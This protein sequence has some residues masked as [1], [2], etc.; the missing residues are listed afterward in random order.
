MN[1]VPLMNKDSPEM[2][3]A[4]RV[5]ILGMVRGI[6]K[7]DAPMVI[8]H[9]TDTMAETG[10]YRSDHARSSLYSRSRLLDKGIGFRVGEVE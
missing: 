7:E 10:L 2:T 9:G 3:D 5:L 4:D 1:V 8:T 6:L